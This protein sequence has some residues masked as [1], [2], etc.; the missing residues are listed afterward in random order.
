MFTLQTLVPFEGSIP[1]ETC[2]VKRFGTESLCSTGKH[3]GAPCAPDG[4][5]SYARSDG[6]AWWSWGP[7]RQG[8]DFEEL[9]RP[10]KREGRAS[11]V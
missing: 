3:Q 11:A 1:K 8:S 5:V 6:A 4:R 2:N 9:Q 7:A 10:G